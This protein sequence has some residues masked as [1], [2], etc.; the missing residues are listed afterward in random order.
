MV[1]TT[2]KEEEIAIITKEITGPTIKAEIGQEIVMEIGEMMV[3]TI[4]GTTIDRTVT[5]GTEI[6]VQVKIM[7]DPGQDI[8]TVCGIAQI[9]EI[10]IV[11]IETK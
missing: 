5:K 1:K 11:M 6:E 9:L 8:G 2:T 3:K 7:V 10:D 4:E